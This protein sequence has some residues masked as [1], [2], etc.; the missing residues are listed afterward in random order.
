MIE[1]N[2]LVQLLTIADS[3]TISKAAEI[4]HLSQPALS[5]SMQRL[6]NELQVPLFH[7]QKNKLTLNENGEIALKYAKEILTNVSDM[8]VKLQ[9]FE[10]SHHILSIGSCAPAPLWQLSPVLSRLYSDMT[11]QSEIKPHEVLTS[12]LLDNLYQIV[13]TTAPI[14]QPGIL[15][16]PYLKEKLF[17]SLVPTHP[18]ANREELS[19]CDLNGQSALILSNIGFWEDI[20][21][22]KMPDSLFLI[23]DDV[24][25]L[26]ELR[27]SSTLVAFSTDITLSNADESEG[28]ISVPL[29]DPDVSVTYYCNIKATDQKY[30]ERFLSYIKNF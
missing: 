12:G 13:I 18:L 2:Q 27:K 1:L 4:L 28:R 20:C 24:E 14:A 22:K 8:A 19:L 23:Q 6:E 7:R 26:H 9:T 17:A 15:S 29:I 10:R 16:Y 21:K 11:I 30:F 5:R 3:G 25:M